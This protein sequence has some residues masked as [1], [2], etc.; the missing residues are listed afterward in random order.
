MTHE[1]AR[2]GT[3]QQSRDGARDVKY[4]ADAEKAEFSLDL[5]KAYPPAAG[6]LSWIRT[7]SFE[8]G[9]QITLHERF[10]LQE[11]RVPVALSLM[12]CRR[13]EVRPGGRIFLAEPSPSER[14]GSLSIYYDDKFFKADVET[15]PISDARLLSSWGD[16]L[17]RIRLI[18]QQTPTQ[19][20]YVIRIA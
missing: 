19:G 9:R 4:S 14:A 16:H 13:P 11:A 18:A 20:E 15:I 5:A 10:A 6:I 12:S 2:A 17:Y 7:I 8:R 1:N 3:H